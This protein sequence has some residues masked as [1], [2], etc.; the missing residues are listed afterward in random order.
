LCGYDPGSSQNA[1]GDSW[2]IYES[3]KGEGRQILIAPSKLDRRED[4]NIRDKRNRQP[5]QLPGGGSFQLIDQPDPI[6]L[7][8]V[9]D[10]DIPAQ[11][12]R[13]EHGKLLITNLDEDVALGQ[14]FTVGSK[15][16]Q[17]TSDPSDKDAS[18]LYPRHAQAMYRKAGAQQFGGGADKV[19]AREDA[20]NN[21]ISPDPKQHDPLQTFNNVTFNSVDGFMLKSGLGFKHADDEQYFREQLDGRDFKVFVAG[22]DD[23]FT[24]P[25][26]GSTEGMIADHLDMPVLTLGKVEEGLVDAHLTHPFEADE[27]VSEMLLMQL[28]NPNQGLQKTESLG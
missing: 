16:M 2:H 10:Q 7:L 17:I 8:S 1:G 14:R 5:S 13:F 22:P 6:I 21:F 23:D 25:A 20:F 11:L 4:A 15:N 9:N 18:W 27:G 28:A 12:M 24:T 19:Q 3:N 26:L